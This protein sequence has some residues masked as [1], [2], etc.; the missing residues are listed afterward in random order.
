M[1]VSKPINSG[2]NVVMG[3][4][5]GPNGNRIEVWAEW[6]ESNISIPNN[7]SSVTVKLY[8]SAVSSSSTWSGSGGGKSYI[9]INGTEYT[10]STSMNYDF[11]TIGHVNSFGSKTVDGIQHNANGTKSIVLGGRFTTSSSYITG[12]SVSKTVALQTIPQYATVSQTVSAR[13]ETSITMKWGSDQT[14]DHIWYSTNNGSTWH[15]VGSV[16]AKTGSYTIT[17]LSA[18]TEYQIKTRVRNQ[19][20]QLLSVSSTTTIKTFDYPYCWLAPDFTLG[21]NVQLIFYN[22]MGRTIHFSIIGADNTVITYP[23]WEISGTSYTGLSNM[24][25]T[26]PALYRTIPNAS[27]GQ[28]KVKTVCDNDEYYYE[29]TITGG[30]YYAKASDCSPEIGSFTYADVRPTSVAIT[31]DSSQIVRNQS[32]VRYTC[33]SFTTKYGATVTSVSVKVNNITYALSASGSDYVGGNDTIDSGR[34]VVATATVTD[35]RG[36][37]ATKDVTVQMLDWSL[38]SA[39]ISLARQN[40]YYSD[41]DITVDAIYSSVNRK[42]RITITYKAKKQGTSTWTVTGTLQDNVQGT[43]VADNQFA[44]DVQVVLVDSFGGTTTYNLNIGKGMPLIY[45]D[46]LRT[47][48]GINCF[49]DANNSL[50]NNGYDLDYDTGTVTLES[51][52]TLYDANGTPSIRRQ[53]RNIYIRGV[54]KPTSAITLG[55]TSVKVAQINNSDFYPSELVYALCQSS[56]TRFYLLQINSSGE[57]FFG[58]LRDIGG[59]NGEYIEAGTSSWFPFSL[60]W[61]K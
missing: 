40:N 43:F 24:Q 45:F 5:K 50:Q 59:N 60:S 48:V 29:A 61:I 57:V 36:I 56:G 11:R 3:S 37:T 42:N 22:P 32:W 14:V 1:A 31:Q 15:S 2:Y 10:I 19:S 39:L 8:A 23:S 58:R 53:G 6:K 4:G 44:W 47:S 38:P 7:T 35:S 12:G 17:G 54:L 41:T 16:S 49:P 26:V 13:T 28:Y 34:N 55:T 30:R 20:S 46:R 21:D 33:G 25:S 9:T 18:F 27:S 51:G 52:W